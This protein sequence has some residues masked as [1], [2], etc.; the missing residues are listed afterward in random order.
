VVEDGKLVSHTPA[1]F[2]ANPAIVK[3]NHGV[4]PK[5]GAR[6]LAE[7]EELAFK[8]LSLLDAAQ[9]K[10]AIIAEK[11]P[12]DIRG[13]VGAQAPKGDPEGIPAAKLNESQVTTLRALLKA[14]AEKMR[15]ECCEADLRAIEDAGI[16]KVHFAWQGAEKPGIGHY[17]RL[18]GPT[19][20]VEFVNVQPDGDGN[21][22]N[23]IHSVWRDLKDGDFGLTKQ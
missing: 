21:P 10:T 7:E 1:F 8:L 14:C 15:S 19:F 11:A 16:E 4:G 13:P 2:G 18:Q 5:N 20:L 6:V 3:D 12:A 9:R 17:Y 22:A 23:H